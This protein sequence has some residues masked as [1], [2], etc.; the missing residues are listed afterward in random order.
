MH[1][2]GIHRGLV[3][4]PILHELGGKLLRNSHDKREV[5]AKSDKQACVH[6]VPLNVVDASTIAI[7]NQSDIRVMLL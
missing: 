2:E 4:E 1:S 6:C 3:V 7:L 5:T